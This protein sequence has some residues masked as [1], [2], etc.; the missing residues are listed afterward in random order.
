[1]D[2]GHAYGFCSAG[3]TVHLGDHGAASPKIKPQPESAAALIVPIVPRSLF[4]LPR[5]AEQ[6]ADLT[7]SDRIDPHPVF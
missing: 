5:P 2:A 1:M 4:Q 6:A 3:N 7:K